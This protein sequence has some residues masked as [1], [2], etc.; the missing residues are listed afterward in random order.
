MTVK[1]SAKE[2]LL[3]MPETRLGKITSKRQLTIPKD[4]YEKLGLDEN[5]EMIL[6]NNELRIR[7]YYRI[8][9]SHDNYA[10]LVLKSILDEGIDNKEEILEEFRLR[11]NLLPLA[12]QDLIED[13]RK[14]TSHD[15]RTSEELDKELFGTE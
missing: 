15:K 1:L 8:E 4:F 3:K 13:V 6:E 9:D 12:V 14:K 10:D 5:V 7:K 11:M 2:N